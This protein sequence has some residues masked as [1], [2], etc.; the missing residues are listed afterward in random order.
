MDTPMDRAP[1]GDPQR[2]R[3]SSVTTH[4][5]RHRKHNCP[6]LPRGGYADRWRLEGE[7]GAINARACGDVRADSG[8]LYRLQYVVSDSTIGEN[9]R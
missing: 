4:R 5:A 9:R 6:T 1:F 8:Y 7:E 3:I 2:R